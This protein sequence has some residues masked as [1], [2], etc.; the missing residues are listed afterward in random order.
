[1]SQQLYLNRSAAVIAL[2][3]SS[4]AQIRAMRDAAKTAG[5]TV[6]GLDTA[7]PGDY[8]IA[9]PSGQLRIMSE[10]S[11]R[12]NYA[13]PDTLLSPEH[14]KLLDDAVLTAFH[15][16]H[17]DGELA[18]GTERSE[19]AAPAPAPA[20]AA[21]APAALVDPVLEAADAA[22][23]GESIT[24]AADPDPASLPDSYGDG[25]TS[26]AEPMP[27]PAEVDLDATAK[28]AKG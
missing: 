25:I 2:A 11:F 21:P 17:P 7:E 15:A 6:T 9:D 22:A 13:R 4:L 5:E 19:A 18:Q 24:A 20:A 12:A 14:A 8:V 27:E 28:P 10:A 1:M 3:L 23:I 16:E 26:R